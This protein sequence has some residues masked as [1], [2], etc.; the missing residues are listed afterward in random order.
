MTG[1]NKKARFYLYVAIIAATAFVT[2]FVSSLYFKNKQ[3]EQFA[4]MQRS[5]DSL[6]REAN[7][8]RAEKVRLLSSI[9]DSLQYRQGQQLG[10][11]ISLLH[12]NKK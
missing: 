2:L 7:H 4:A 12:R 6:D 3:Q 10:D 1:T 5:M 9:R 11:S 8:L